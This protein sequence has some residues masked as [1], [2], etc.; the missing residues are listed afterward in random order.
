MP[1]VSGFLLDRMHNAGVN[2]IFGVPGDY[3][4]SFFKEVSGCDGVELVN[5]TDEEGAGFAADAY[6]RINGIGA[7][8][9]TYV[10]GALKIT[11]AVACA[12]AERSPII[13]ISGAPGLKERGHCIFQMTNGHRCQKE[14]FERITCAS[15]VLDNPNTAGYEIDRVLSEMQFHKQPIYIE[16]PRD[17][18]AKPV[19]YDVYKQGTPKSPDSDEE[20]ITEAMKEVG[21]WLSVAKRPVLLAGVQIARF[22]LGS[23][24]IKFAERLNIPVCT[25]LLSKSTVNER[26]ELFRGIYMGPSSKPEVMELVESSDCLLVLGN[27]HNDIIFGSQPKRK[28]IISCSVEG[29]RVK[30]HTFTNVVFKDFC[31]R[32]FKATLSPKVKPVYQEIAEI[33]KFIPEEK[34]ITTDRLFEKI[35]SILKKDMVVVS[36]IGDSLF[37]A[38]DLTIPSKNH[39]LSPAF[40]ASMGSAIPGA[41]GANMARPDARVIVLVGDGS[42]Q[43]SCS[44]LSTINQ[45]G[46]NPIVFVL[47]N[48]GYTTERQVIDGKFNDLADWNYHKITEM[49]GGTGVIVHTESELEDA[50]NSALKSKELFIINV[51]VEQKDISGA[52]K[53]MT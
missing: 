49:F 15:T 12:Y 16:L 4:L 43:M 51:A 26:H 47:N 14:I 5:T 25:T 50:V 7:V 46:F 42:F 6:A 21:E 18:A 28:N 2:H 20:N 40:Y 52:L 39:F 33:E 22:D 34:K 53:R 29:L 27:I 32:L 13:V 1:N 30:N 10:V 48:K 11:N 19:T 3:I 38:V 8:C 37:G 23:D 24:L 9:V 45:R 41:L 35:N 17:V 36:D 44:E 31:H